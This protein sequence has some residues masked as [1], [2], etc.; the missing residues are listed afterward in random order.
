MSEIDAVT[1]ALLCSLGQVH[2]LLTAQVVDVET[3]PE[4]SEATFELSISGPTPVE[5]LPPELRELRGLGHREIVISGYVEASHGDD[6]ITWSFNVADLGSSGWELSRDVTRR[7][8]HG[9]DVHKALP[10]I[11]FA[12]W[13]ELAD[14]LP[15]LVAELLELPMPSATG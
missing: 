7:P 11:A 4:M 2:Q 9:D 5:K 13:Q 14:S 8:G 12:N 10:D 3:R 15:Q 6:G 1:N